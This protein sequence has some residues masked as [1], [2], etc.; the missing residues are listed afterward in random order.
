MLK[1]FR[2]VVQNIIPDGEHGAYAV[3]TLDPA[4]LFIS[5]S[6]TFSLSSDVWKEKSWPTPGTFVMLNFLFKKRAGWR[7]E[8]AR[9]YSPEDEER[10]IQTTKL[11]T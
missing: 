11:I 1:E 6:V 10:F 3:C 2:A 8:K 9:L 7:A 4:N 5:G